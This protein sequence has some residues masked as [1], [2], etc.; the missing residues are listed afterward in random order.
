[1]KRPTIGAAALLG[2]VLLATV[3]AAASSRIDPARIEPWHKIGDV[4]LGMLRP[5]VEYRYGAGDQLSPDQTE[6][7]VPG[8]RLAV[9]FAGNRV[10]WIETTS[11]RYRTSTAIGIGTH[12]PLG[13]CHHTRTNQCEHRWNGFVYYAPGQVW[14]LNTCFAGI[15]TYASLSVETGIIHDL[16]LGYGSP[17]VCTSRKLPPLSRADKRAITN[18]IEQA[19]RSAQFASTRVDHFISPRSTR[20]YAAATISGTFTNGSDI[21]PALVIVHKQ[22]GKW[23]VVS[24]G[25]SGVGCGQVPIKYLAEMNL[26]CPG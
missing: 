26:N 8:G 23:H 22:A 7:R 4:G 15:P 18:T 16:I 17:A 20:E 11:P 13:P 10:T 2:A 25:S 14:R 5:T 24:Y 3:P 6:L 19:L 12:I 9:G 21:Q 1:M